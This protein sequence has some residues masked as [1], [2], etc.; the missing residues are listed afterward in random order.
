MKTLHHPSESRV[1]LP[2]EPTESEVRVMVLDDDAVDIEAVRRCLSSIEGLETKVTGCADAACA[3]EQVARETFDVLFVDYDLI[4]MTG[5]EALEQLS[6]AGCRVPAVLLTG[7]HG[8]RLLHEAL[9]AGVMDYVRKDQLHPGLLEQTVYRVLEKAELSLRVER[10]Q[11]ELEY[12]VERLRKRNEEVESFYHNVSHELRTPLTGAQ[13]F[14]SLMQE[15]AAGPLTASQSKLL[16]ATLRS[17]DQMS[18]CV[19]DMLDA[20]RIETGKLILKLK[21]HDLVVVLQDAVESVRASATRKEID[22]RLRGLDR[23]VEGS[24]DPHRVFQ[25]AA[26]LISNAIKFTP[27]GGAVHVAL[28]RRPDESLEVRVGDSGPGIPEGDEQRVFDRLYQSSSEDAA[29]LGGL[30]MGLYISKQIVELHGGRISCARSSLGGAQITF[31][32]PQLAHARSRREP[33]RKPV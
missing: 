21:T 12:T 24:F 15:G 17:C 14:V 18:H 27:N 10:K 9:R 2:E 20:A 28:H 33:S 3:L 26:N 25:V 29:L 4:D 23:R 31:T 22:L 5:L 1:S 8:E 32:L 6:K 30:G 13:E 11:I 19:D 7:Q 16:A